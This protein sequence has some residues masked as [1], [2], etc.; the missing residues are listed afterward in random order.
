M[1]K[2]RKHGS[3]SSDSVASGRPRAGFKNAVDFFKNHRNLVEGPIS[4]KLALFIKK[5]ALF[6]KKSVL[7]IKKMV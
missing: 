5:S 3:C 6:V 4:E 2:E 1:I 7:F